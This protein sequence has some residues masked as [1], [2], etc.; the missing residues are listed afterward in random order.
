VHAAGLAQFS[1][2]VADTVILDVNNQLR[3]AEL[4]IV[5]KSFIRE[6]HDKVVQEVGIT[7]AQIDLGTCTQGAKA[8]VI[9]APGGVA[10][11]ASTRVLVKDPA[12]G[13]SSYGVLILE[14]RHYSIKQEWIDKIGSMLLPGSVCS[15]ELEEPDGM[16]P[17]APEV[18][19][20]DGKN[21]QYSDIKQYEYWNAVVG[22]VA[23]DFQALNNK[24]GAR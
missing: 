15:M 24:N 7:K 17:T 6:K 14:E 4:R 23:T 1:A 20:V 5:L 21:L 13:E 8:A 2:A 10:R 18:V 19:L 3:T 12:S 11:R 9:S 16:P 22:V